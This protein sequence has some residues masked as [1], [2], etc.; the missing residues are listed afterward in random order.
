MPSSKFNQ[1]PVPRRR[2]AICIAPAGSCLPHYDFNN[3]PFLQ[4]TIDWFDLDPLD[5]IGA[6]GYCLLAKTGPEPRYYG[7]SAPA[8]TRIAAEVWATGT[9]PL[10]NVD[11]ILFWEARAPVTWHFTA[12]TVD[13]DVPFDSGLLSNINLPGQDYRFARILN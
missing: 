8:G 10:W 4:A 2:P 12:V 1:R 7:E 6:S 5:P 9:P 13:P 11:A 3:P